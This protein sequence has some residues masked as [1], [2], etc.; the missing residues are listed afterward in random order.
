MS[1]E[2][3]DLPDGC[4]TAPEQDVHVGDA[5]RSVVLPLTDVPAQFDNGPP[6]RYWLEANPSFALV[7][8]VFESYAVVAPVAI[9]E[10]TGNEELFEVVLESARSVRDLVRLPA[11]GSAWGS[12]AIA[13][14]SKPHTLRTEV[15]K[16]LRVASMRDDACGQLEQ[17][18]ARAFAS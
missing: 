8:R 10:V 1:D 6:R 4:W 11:L 14:L 12:P 9:A 17:R 5:C 7:I 2:D 16:F 13:V 3:L 15:L 18:V